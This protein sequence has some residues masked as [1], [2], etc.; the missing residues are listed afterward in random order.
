MNLAKACAPGHAS[1][2]SGY[3][4]SRMPANA[5]RMPLH[6]TH[7]MRPGRRSNAVWQYWIAANKAD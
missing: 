4:P 3:T 1:S 5:L 2:R 6:S 7:S